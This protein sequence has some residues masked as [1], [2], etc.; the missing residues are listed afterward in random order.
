MCDLQQQL[1]R[2]PH[3]REQHEIGY[4]DYGEQEVGAIK[5][6]ADVVRASDDDAAQ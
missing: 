2:K 1:S 6:I 5:D 3:Q 4:K